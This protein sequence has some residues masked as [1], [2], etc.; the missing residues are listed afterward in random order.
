MKILLGEPPGVFRDSVR[1][2]LRAELLEPIVTEVSTVDEA[3]RAAASARPEIALLS[4][5][6]PN[7]GGLSAADRIARAVPA[8]RI[9][10][11]TDQRDHALLIRGVQVG[12][13]GFIARKGPLSDLLA[14]IAAAGRGEAYVPSI[15]LEGIL[16][17]AAGKSLDADGPADRIE[18]LTDREWQVLAGLALGDG[19]ERLGERLGISPQTARTHVQNVLAKLGVHSRLEA[20]ALAR[21]SGLLEPWA[22]GA[23]L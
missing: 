21:R 15:M 6:L 18:R 16:R 12:A 22:A 11:V 23:A 13:T 19:N 8:C 1:S 14:A 10:L 3:H 4:A 9:V 5:S 20:A 7:E 17:K 2:L